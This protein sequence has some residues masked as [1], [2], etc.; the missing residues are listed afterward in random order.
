LSSFFPRHYRRIKAPI[1]GQPDHTT[2][3]PATDKASSSSPCL[4]TPCEFVCLPLLSPPMGLFSSP[5][6]VYK[7]AADVDL[8]PGSDEFYISP[9]VKGLLAPAFLLRINS[10]F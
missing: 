2:N 8:G 9:N 4:S 7:P 5:P 3:S 1:L 10:V 6:K